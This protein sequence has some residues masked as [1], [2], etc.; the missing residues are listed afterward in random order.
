M[1]IAIGHLNITFGGGLD[2]HLTELEHLA[3]NRAILPYVKYLHLLHH[4]VLQEC[5]GKSVTI[6][7]HA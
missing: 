5:A 1:G 7:S 3:E 6:L 2:A 4:L